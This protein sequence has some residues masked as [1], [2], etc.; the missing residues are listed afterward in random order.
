MIILLFFV[1]CLFRALD[2]TEHCL[3]QT[4]LRCDETTQEHLM[5][6]F[7]PIRC[8][9]YSLCPMA[10]ESKAVTKEMPP[11]CINPGRVKHGGEC[12][13]R[14]ALYC[15]QDF[16]GDFSHPSVKKDKVCM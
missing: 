6:M 12:N 10:A 8:K 1:C 11:S 15:I 14:R 2:N 16:Y 4:I 7:E 3:K 5:E 9:T 13:P